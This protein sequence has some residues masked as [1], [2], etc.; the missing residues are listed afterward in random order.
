MNQQRLLKRLVT[1]Q[2]GKSSS[3]HMDNLSDA[4]LTDIENILN[5]QQGNV[6][7]SKEMGLKDLQGHFHSHS[8]P[9][10]QGLGNEIAAQITEFETRLKSVS[11]SV[12]EDNKDLSCF[13]W[14]MQATTK[15]SYSSLNISAYIKINA[16]GLV[17]LESAM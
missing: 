17:T 4:I 5:C 3:A 14:R 9:D 10:T 13:K 2:Q 15:D 6:L 1:W 12:D 11:V 7:I 8:A 16:N